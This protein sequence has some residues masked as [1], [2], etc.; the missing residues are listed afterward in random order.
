MAKTQCDFEEAVDAEGGADHTHL[1]LAKNVCART[2]LQLRPDLGDAHRVQAVCDLHEADYDHAHAEITVALSTLPNDAEA[3]RVAAMIDEHQNRWSD[4]MIELQ[5]AFG[6]DPRNEEVSYYL[7]DVY[8]SMR[9]YRE[10]AQLLAKR[11]P[12]NEQE[13]YW[14]LLGQAQIKLCTG[15]PEAAQAIL[16]QIPTDFN[17]TAE[18]AGTRYRTALCRHDYGAVVRVMAATPANFAD[19]V[20]VGTPPES[21]TDGLLARLRGD[22]SKAQGIFIAGRRNLEAAW[23]GRKK[24][25]GYFD[26]SSL[27]DAGISGEKEKAIREA[28]QMES[29]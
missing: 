9:R 17:P 18:I 26:A 27:F 24:D 22:E 16:D 21:W 3:L 19:D 7:G 5:K 11:T 14:I 10:W 2:A 6:L 12:R 4:A 1:R 29:P 13:R 20:Y 15:N 8:Q 25:A 23:G 28:R